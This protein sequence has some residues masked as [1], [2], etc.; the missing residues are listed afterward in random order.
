MGTAPNNPVKWRDRW[1]PTAGEERAIDGVNT[2]TLAR[3][4][5]LQG[6]MDIRMITSVGERG[7]HCS[8]QS[9]EVV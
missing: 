4:A 1:W 8:D 7:G 3:L 9:G 2:V 5:V 6:P